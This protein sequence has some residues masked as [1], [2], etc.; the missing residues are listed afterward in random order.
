MLF[1][2]FQV[3]RNGSPVDRVSPAKF[4]YRRMPDRPTSEVGMLRTLR[5]DLYLVVGT[6]ASGTER[7]TFRFYVNPL[8]SWIWI[9]LLALITGATISL[10]PE[11]NQ[12]R[13][14]A[15]GAV[16]RSQPAGPAARPPRDGAARKASDA[17][18]HPRGDS[19][20]D[21]TDDARPDEADE[22]RSD[23]A[24]AEGEEKAP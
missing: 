12:R 3:G 20:P 24:D 8:V 4:V 21:E 19:T 10:W 16:R 6:L 17:D 11:V 15:W 5:D 1:A 18:H 2:D 23:E 22:A 7:S 14:G 9:G 13:L